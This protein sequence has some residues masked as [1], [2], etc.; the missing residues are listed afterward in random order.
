VLG[1]SALYLILGLCVAAFWLTRWVDS[2]GGPAG[3]W[4][5]FG[6]LAPAISVPVH[7]IVGVTPFPSDVIAIANGTVY[8]FWLGCVLS[9]LG[10]YLTAFIE[11]QIGRRSNRDF[12][13]SAWL[14]RAPAAIRRFPVGHPAFIIGSRL[15]PWAGGHISTLLPGAMGVPLGRFAWCSALGIVPPAMV[16]AGIGAG[17]LKL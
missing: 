6:L 5:R 16:M 13:V 10:W 1:S 2:L 8:G 17:L 12:D 4:E 15:V 11:F 7:A 9:W 14:S 3:I